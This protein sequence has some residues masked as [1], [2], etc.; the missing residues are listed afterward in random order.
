VKAG[1][2]DTTRAVRDYWQARPCGSSLSEAE[3]GSKEFFDEIEEARY[4][5]EPFIPAFA[6]FERWTGRRVLEIGV[7][8]GTDFVRFA[9]AGA[10][11]SGI[12]LTEA[13]I[14]LVRRRLELEGL[15]PDLQI[16]DAEALPFPEESF[17][18]VYSWGVLHHVPDTERAVSEIRRV[19]KPA[20]EARIMLYSRRSCVALGTWLRYALLRGRPWRSVASVLS[21]YMES[22]GTKAYTQRELRSMFR[23][24]SRSHF[25]PILTV[26]DRRVAGPLIRVLSPRFGWFIGI[27]AQR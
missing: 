20:G 15:V 12:D 6:D 24:F 4:R 3:P 10:T 27:R 18:L 14:D 11:L 5:R 17:D 2:A 26:Y 25:E 22:P 21:E 16:A 13:S 9:R 19:L 23:D 1:V 7:G 8:L